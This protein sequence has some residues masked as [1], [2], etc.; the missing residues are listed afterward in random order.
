MKTADKQKFFVSFFQERNIFFLVLLCCTAASGPVLAQASLPKPP[1]PFTGKID[2]SRYKAT[3]AWPSEVKAPANAPNIV[4]V[5]LDDVGF[6]ASTAMGGV[7]DTPAL[8]QLASGGLR[9]NNFHVNA[10]CSPTRGALLSGRNNHQIGFGPIAESAAGYPGFNS[11]W[12]KS[13]ASIAEV[14]KDNG[15]STAAF[16]KWHNTPVWEVSAAGPFDRWPTY[17]G[18]EYFYGFMG[19]ATSQWEPSL[20]RDTSAVEPPATPAQG[21][22]LNHDLANDAIKWLHQHDAI[23]PEKPFFLYYATGGTH[24]PH[25]VPQQWIDRFRGRFDAGYDNLR[26]EI[27][28]RQKA[29]GIIP[30]DADISP[31]PA[32]LPAWDT[33]SADEKKLLSRQMEVYAAYLAQTDYEVGRVLQAIRDEGRADNTLVLYIIGDNGATEEGSPLGGDLRRGDGVYDPVAV[34]L[35]RADELGSKA[36][37]NIYGAGWA[38]ALNTPFPWA[39]QVA[40]HLGGIT[41][42]LIVSWPAKINARGD[43]RRQFSHIVDIAPTIY[44]AAGITP[45]DVVNGVA[46]VPL[47]GKSLLPTFDDPNVTTGHTVQYF[48]L[49]GNRGIYKDGWF[50]GRRFLLPWES[51]RLDKWTNEDPDRLHPWELYDLNSDYSQAHNLAD[52]QP[53]KL[54]E[55]VALYDSEARRNNAYPTAPLRLPQ[56]SPAAGKNS[57]TYRDGDTRLP[58]RVVPSLGGRSHVFVADILSPPAGAASGV[59]LAEGGRYGG[60][61]LYVKNGRLIYENNAQGHNHEIIVADDPLPPGKVE[62][63]YE[64]T[65]TPHEPGK[66]DAYGVAVRDGHGRLLVNGKLEGEG[67]IS[68]FGMFGETFDVGSDLGSPVSNDYETPFAF[69][70]KIEKVTLNLK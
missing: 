63:S 68:S 24:S 46:Q 65:V 32:E 50:A 70:G 56:P 45:P 49:I 27:Y 9:Y 54:A 13:A 55:L 14:L 4:L 7:I 31:R 34:Q 52:K 62:V 42:P 48:E 38:Y 61:S 33:L 20:Y 6:G 51:G 39:K 17:V 59:I 36:L 57:F 64:F 21:Y 2:P 15:Y 40:S 18:F 53:E 11:V 41:D 69:N 37:N 12:P 25:Q 43:V 35:A 16:G 44:Q 1:P 22:N 47:E 26:Q 10:M 23:V 58:L 30:A 19:A 5:L 3:P 66:A 8:D 67:D 29:R 60:F 28:Q